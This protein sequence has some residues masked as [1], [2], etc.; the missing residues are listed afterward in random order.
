MFLILLD[1]RCRCINLH[2][3]LPFRY[4]RLLPDNNAC[5]SSDG[6][7]KRSRS[8][9]PQQKKPKEE[10]NEEGPPS[11]R[12]R[13]DPVSYREESDD[14]DEDMTNV[15]MEATAAV[16]GD[17]GCIDLCDDSSD[18]EARTSEGRKI[19]G[20]E[21]EAEPLKEQA[22]AD[23]SKIEELEQRIEQLDSKIALLENEKKALQGELEQ[24]EKIIS[25]LK[26]RLGA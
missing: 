10:P 6:Q 17:K 25:I 1:S 18:E 26:R 11:K 24:K 15:K 16:N 20:G 21:P 7:K 22:S 3:S 8:N 5:S 23:A 12:S 2:S 19:N 4:F 14:S 13:T 9:I